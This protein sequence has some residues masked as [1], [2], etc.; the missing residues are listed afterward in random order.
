MNY[1]WVEYFLDNHDCNISENC[2]CFEQ[3]YDGECCNAESDYDK[4]WY[5]SLNLNVS[6]LKCIERFA[7]QK[8]KFTYSMMTKVFNAPMFDEKTALDDT[9]FLSEEEARQELETHIEI[10]KWYLDVKLKD[11]TKTE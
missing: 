4:K 8:E 5:C 9:Y 6:C 7:I 1:I 3:T 2:P 10:Y 11:N